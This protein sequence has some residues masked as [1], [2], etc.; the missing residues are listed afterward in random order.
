MRLCC[1]ENP[2]WELDFQSCFQIG[3]MGYR[4]LGGEAWFH[5]RET[6]RLLIDSQ[7][8][9]WLFGILALRVASVRE[10]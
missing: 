5:C 1:V 10:N 4:F 9:S 3:E 2:L 8:V 6:T 7:R